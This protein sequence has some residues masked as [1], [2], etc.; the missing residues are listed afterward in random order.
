VHRQPGER[1]GGEPLH[2]TLIEH[3]AAP[4]FPAE[5][6]VLDDVEVV[7]E[8]EVLID[9][10]DAQRG[11]VPRTADADGAALEEELAG[12]GGVDAADA[13]D[14][15]RLAGAVVADERGH[16]AGAHRQV[17]GTEHLDGTEA[18]LDPAQ[19]QQRGGGHGVSSDR[20]SRPTRPGRAGCRPGAGPCR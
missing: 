2:R 3:Q 9:D 11:R 20:R 8:G 6:H 5:E 15:G 18:L 7:A 14:E 17:D 4:L 13:F 16:L 1:L 12:I 19:L 10:L